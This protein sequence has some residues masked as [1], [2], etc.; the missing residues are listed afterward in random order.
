M[1]NSGL[2]PLDKPE[3]QVGGAVPKAA[4]YGGVVFDDHGRVLLRE[5]TNHFD[6]YV[7]T[8]AKGAPQSRESPR[9]TALREVREETGVDA[10]IVGVIPGV[11]AGGT[12]DCVYFLMKPISE[13]ELGPDQLETASL[14][15]ASED[16]ARML[17][18]QTTNEKG[19]KRDL[20]VLAAAFK[21][22]RR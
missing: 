14:R 11:Y 21:A 15:W 20:D 2:P 10:E 12:G 13:H 4:K 17:I 3:T 7:W 5:P 1:L 18:R 16:E 8:F 19:R 9:Q 6:G 22:L